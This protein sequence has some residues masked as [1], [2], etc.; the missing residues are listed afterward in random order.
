MGNNTL[1]EGGQYQR[2]PTS[3]RDVWREFE[4]SAKY[5]FNCPKF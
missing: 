3:E 2:R 4:G 1:V 5:D